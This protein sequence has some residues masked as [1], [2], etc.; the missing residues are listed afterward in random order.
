MKK[1]VNIIILGSLVLFIY[2]CTKGGDQLSLS[3]NA[4]SVNSTLSSKQIIPIINN[5]TS[6]G[7]LT[8]WYD[9]TANVMTFTVNWSRD[10]SVNAKDTIT[11]VQFYDT[12]SATT[13]GSLARSIIV[14]NTNNSGSILLNLAGNLCFSNT[15]KSNFL[16]GK[17]YIVLCSKK[18][19]NGIIR[20]QLV[21]TKK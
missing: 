7:S 4:D 13:M 21:T 9:E 8:G 11:S 1:I 18:Y 10:I 17:W 2:S 14:S 3:G 5:D 6:K 15:E 12:A 19:P 20:G 16:A